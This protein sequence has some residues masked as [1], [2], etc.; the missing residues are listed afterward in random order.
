MENRLPPPRTK[1]HPEDKSGK[2]RSASTDTKMARDT[3]T[4]EENDPRFAEMGSTRLTPPS[5]S[6]L[7]GE[8]TITKFVELLPQRILGDFQIKRKLGEGAMGA[9]YKALQL[10]ANGEELETPRPVALK[11]LF[12]HIA[13]IP[14][15]VERLYREGSVMGLLDHPNIIQ[16]YAIGEAEGYHYVAMEY[17]SGQNMQKWLTQLGRLSVADA[18]A[19]TLDCAR[20]LAY[21][22]GNN[23][24]HRDIKPDNILVTRTGVVKVA[25][26][27]M[28]KTYDDMSLTQ[29]GHAVGTPWYMPM[30]QAKNAKEIDGRSD[31]YALGCT[32]YAFLTGTPPFAG[33]TLVDVIQAKEVG[34]FPP[35]R[36]TNQ[37]VPERLDL[38]LAKMTA[39]LP[40][41]RYQTCEEVIKDLEDLGL[42]SDT[43]SFLQIKP[44][45]GKDTE[46]TVHKMSIEEGTVVQTGVGALIRTPVER[47]DNA[48]YLIVKSAGGKSN[49]YRYLTAQLQQMFADGKIKPSAQVSHHPTENF[50]ALGTFKEFQ[51]AALAEFT[52]KRADKY[53]ARQRGVYSKIREDER[54]RA[55]KLRASRRAIQLS[56]NARYWLDIGLKTILALLGL[57]LIGGF[58]YWICTMFL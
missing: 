12:P 53:T 40:K 8:G 31:I 24:I 4:P 37:D 50:R 29:T 3:A 30:E 1:K 23:V 43:L 22:H 38:I 18:V 51:G 7:A 49:T 42:A 5:K 9:V 19:V 20:A 57:G 47:D 45:S 46:D 48:W 11:I 27:G 33:R 25:D 41:Y 28:V 13:S 36:Q 17:V 26:L 10:T 44:A 2:V 16:A 21:A 15:L 55:E 34:T 56:P 32:L 39:K 14:K 52:K 35:A 6:T 54:Q 58:M